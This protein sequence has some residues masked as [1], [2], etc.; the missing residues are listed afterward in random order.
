MPEIKTPAKWYYQRMGTGT[1][2]GPFS[3]V[4]MAG[5]LAT[6]DITP[7]TPTRQGPADR[8]RAFRDYREFATAKE[9]PPEVIARHL[10]QKASDNPPF[11]PFRWMY[12]FLWLCGA[13]ALYTIG[14]FFWSHFPYAHHHQDSN[15]YL[16]RIFRW[17]FG[18][19]NP[20]Q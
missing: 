19:D 5:L 4:E 17:M 2:E 12:Q 13:V 6:G 10:E 14:V 15:D 11:N 9:M 7:E 18:H 16:M 1:V 8:W 20:H 3:L